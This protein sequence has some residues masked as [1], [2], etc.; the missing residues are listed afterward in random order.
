MI[1]KKFNVISGGASGIFARQVMLRQRYGR[2]EICKVPCPRPGKGTKGQQAQRDRWKDAGNYYASVKTLGLEQLYRH[3][4]PWGWNVQNRAVS[5]FYHAPEIVSVDSSDYTGLPGEVL[6]INATDDFMV[7]Q[8]TVAIYDHDN[9]LVESGRA[10]QLP[11]SEYWEYTAT[12]VN[13]S[14][15]RVEITATDHPGNEDK[16][17][18][19]VEGTAEMVTVLVTATGTPNQPVSRPKK[20]FMPKRERRSL[21]QGREPLPGS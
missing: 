12:R 15:G 17:V 6:I 7:K 20:A 9:V 11:D 8:V 21:R 4:L 16:M 1:Q 2:L 10:K 3:D 13:N 18:L 14:G 19:N 5:D